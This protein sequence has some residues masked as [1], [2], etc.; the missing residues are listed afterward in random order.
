MELWDILDEHGN[1][2]GKVMERGMFSEELIHLG[3][4]V[5]IVNSKNEI[6]IQKR[7]STKKNSPNLWMM[8][9]GSAIA[10]ENSKDTI[11]REV[12]EELGI[13]I[14]TQNLLLIKQYKV[15]HEKNPP[16][17]LD[18]YFLKQEININDIV[19]QEEELS[20]VK[21]ATWE[22]CEK[23]HKDKQFLDFRWEAVR[24]LLNCISYIGKSVNVVIDRP[25]NSFHPDWKNHQYLTNNGYV[26]NTVSGDG[27]EIDCYV[28]GENKP[29]KTYTGKCIALIHR[30]DDNDDKLII[31]P[32][33][34]NYTN[35]Q[36]KA[37]VEYQEKYFNSVIMR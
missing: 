7:S 16:V 26:P 2:T 34:T 17:F 29:L 32:E 18:T 23:I 12:K 24:D 28:L 27:E 15:K 11:V 10:G 1:K 37:L 9:G 3:A 36:I 30:L 35:E 25:I 20:E 4:D 8:T 31:V 6:L 22:E 33:D 13:N 14:V 19:I 21:W 5:W